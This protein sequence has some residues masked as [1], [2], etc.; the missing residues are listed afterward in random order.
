MIL[1]PHHKPHFSKVDPLGGG[2]REE[3]DCEKCGEN[4]IIL[5]E[6]LQDDALSAFWDHVQQDIHKDPEWFDFAAG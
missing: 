1:H 2:L 6:G 5:E 4:A 3:I